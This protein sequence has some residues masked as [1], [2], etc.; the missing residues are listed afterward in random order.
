MVTVKFVAQ[1]GIENTGTMAVTAGTAA[2]P[3]LFL[4]GD[5]SSG[6]FSP[7]TG[8]LAL[9]TAS[10]E[11]FRILSSGAWSVGSDGVSYGTSGQVFVSGGAGAAPSWQAVPAVTSVQLSGGTTGLSASGGP[12]TST[13]TL[14]LGGTLAIA[15][16]GTGQTSASAAIN[17]LVPAQTGNSGKFLTTSGTAVSWAAQPYDLGVTISGKPDASAV[18]LSFVAVRAFTLPSS[19]AGSL[20]VAG[21]SATDVAVFTINKNGSSIGTLQ[22]AAAGNTGT[23]SGSAGGFAVGDV[24]TITAPASQDSTLADISLVLITNLA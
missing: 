24:L 2:A 22:F 3:G 20:A 13:G 4:G 11:R 23:F 19:F 16:G 12:I 6:L 10:I 15:N 14:T 9:S 1:Y 7:G 17:A 5:D 8:S 18:V 21:T